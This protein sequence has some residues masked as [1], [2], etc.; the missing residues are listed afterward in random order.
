MIDICIHLERTNFCFPHYYINNNI[1]TYVCC[2]CIIYINI[3]LLNKH[4]NTYHQLLKLCP[5]I[6]LRVTPDLVKFPS[7]VNIIIC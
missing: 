2:I 3:L 6:P 7:V 5:L 1:R 4:T